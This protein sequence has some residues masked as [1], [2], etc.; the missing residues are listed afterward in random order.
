MRDDAEGLFQHP[1]RS[2]ACVDADIVERQISCPDVGF[3]AAL[4][5]SYGDRKFFLAK[6]LRNAAFSN[7]SK[8]HSFFYHRNPAERQA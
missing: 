3:V 4:S 7:E 5:Q 2:V 6:D 8:S 1:L